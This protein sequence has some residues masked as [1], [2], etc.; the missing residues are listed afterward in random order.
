MALN[1]QVC[2]LIYSRL[3]GSLIRL[4]IIE[5]ENQK[6]PVLGFGSMLA[7]WHHF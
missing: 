4:V 7:V 1:A 5:D 6:A 3:L 2:Q